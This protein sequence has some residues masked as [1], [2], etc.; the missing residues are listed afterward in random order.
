MVWL[1]VYDNP[2]SDNL[3]YQVAEA[4]IAVDEKVSLYRWRHFTSV[5]KIIGYAPGT[6]GAAC[7]GQSIQARTPPSS[8]LQTMPPAPAQ[9]CQSAL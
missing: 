4:L 5:H 1:K 9:R 6:V 3:L 7:V 8:R 2:A